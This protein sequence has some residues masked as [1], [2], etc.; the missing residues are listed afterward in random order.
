MK[1]PLRKLF[2]KKASNST[3]TIADDFFWACGVLSMGQNTILQDYFL[4]NNMP[5][6]IAKLKEG[7]DEESRSNIDRYLHRMLTLPDFKISK[8]YRIRREF[9]ESFQTEREK[10]LTAQFFQNL[11]QY[12]TDVVLNKDEYNP[13]TFLFHHGLY[14]QNDKL[15]KYIAG[16]DFIDGGA[17][18][19]DSAIM[20]N[21]HYNPKKVWSFEI[22]KKNASLYKENLD[23]N[24]IAKDKYALVD[25][26]LG[27]LKCS[28]L[29]DD[30]GGQGA[31]IL[32]QGDSEIKITDIDSFVK[33]NSL[34]VGFIKSDVEGV[35]LDALEG[36]A[37]TIQKHRPVLCL[38]IYH[39][40][41][42]F[43]D[44]PPRVREICGGEYEI[45]ITQ[46]H[47]FYDCNNEIV[48]FAYPKE[49]DQ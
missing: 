7:F 8:N 42:E 39:N 45:M 35:G 29:I 49:L 24:N 9:L 28:L 37:E 44:M 23:N 19:G 3:T 6:K 32:C 41:T 47:P 40:P 5:E 11:P 22:S 48:I 34:Q 30:I 15:K 12:K 46:L 1:N 14:F 26:G 38:A 16:K 13:D 21:K 17:Y 10:D 2:H 27:K 43:F 18:I 4:K 25:M 36:M 31:N 33:E 20:L